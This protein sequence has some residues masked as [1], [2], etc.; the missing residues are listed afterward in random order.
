MIRAIFIL[1]IFTFFSITTFAQFELHL[2][3][4][5]EED[6]KLDL[7]FDSRF[8]FIGNNNVKTTGIKLGLNY[9]NMFK[10]GLGLNTLLL[11]LKYDIEEE[12]VN[13]RADLQYVYFSPYFEYVFYNTR[14]WE[15]CLSTQIGV[16]ASNYQITD[17]LGTN[18]TVREGL[19]L[20]YE[21]ST[22]I[23][24]KFLKYFAIGTG[25]G[26]RVMIVQNTG[27]N[28]RFTSPE[29]ILKLKVYLG[30][31]WRNVTGKSVE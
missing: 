24:Y 19:M 15:F 29:Y 31:I 21:P 3:E 5:F 10:V 9:N 16:G 30:K 1:C 22:H 18:K 27:V 14:R 17:S 26:Y 6:G 2:K 4:S 13:Y 12:G 8:S 20:S 7:K 11:P 23:D 28:E 25:V